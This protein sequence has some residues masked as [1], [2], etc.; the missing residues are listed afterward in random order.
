MHSVTPPCVE[1]VVA[2]GVPARSP[3]GPEVDF[4]A[5]KR[6]GT[7]GMFPAHLE[8]TLP[9]F[10][11]D[12]LIKNGFLQR[13]AKPFPDSDRAKVHFLGPGSRCVRA[14]PGGGGLQGG[15]EQYSWE[16]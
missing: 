3:G 4:S 16:A 7:W 14:S 8:S 5:E 1:N 2:E 13:S 15:G 10:G 6:G 12:V 11:G 9:R